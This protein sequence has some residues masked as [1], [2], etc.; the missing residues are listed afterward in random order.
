MTVT[1]MDYLTGED[2]IPVPNLRFVTKGNA[3]TPD[4]DI[5]P[6][7]N[8]GF[9]AFA[10][11]FVRKYGVSNTSNP[12]VVLTPESLGIIRSYYEETDGRINRVSDS[13]ARKS[14]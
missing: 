14:W 10:A 11:Q 2:G 12:P 6:K 13:R 1:G 4:S 7:T 5:F 8:P 9:A 3:E